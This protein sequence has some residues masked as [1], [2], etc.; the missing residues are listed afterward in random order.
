MVSTAL[1]AF[2]VLAFTGS[3]A[4]KLVT[5]AL[6]FYLREGLRAS[7]L[8]VSTLTAGYMLGRS[9]TAYFSGRVGERWR[10]TPSL[11]LILSGLL[12][13]LYPLARSWYEVSGLSFI[14]GALMGLT[15]PVIQHRVMASA[16]DGR[17]G[18][19]ISSYFFIGSMAGPAGDAIYGV[20]LSGSPLLSV[21]TVSLSLYFISS[22]IAYLGSSRLVIT[23]E[24]G[25]MG[26]NGGVRWL[27][28]LGF[29]IGGMASIVGSSITYVIMREWFLLSRGA[30]ALILSAVGGLSLGSKL[31]S[32]YLLDEL[33]AGPTLKSLVAL[34]VA[35][36]LLMGIKSLPCFLAGLF[37]TFIVVGS[38][39]PV[40]RALAHAAPDPASAVGKLNSFGNVGTV[41]GLLVVGAG[42]DVL[43]PSGVFSPLIVL[44]GPYALLTAISTLKIL[45][46]GS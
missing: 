40:S 31:L 32:G 44:L 30:V 42:I 43:P 7:F 34:L 12:V 14:Q 8:G 25:G 16:G 13:L 46:E 1:I 18:R 45:R 22:L 20:F 3:L 23:R 4:T 21:V 41:T 29:G 35:G 27:L 26:R 17:I 37:L 11:C 15:W 24:G 36:T 10:F 28:V 2:T 5:P 19:A 33:G 9:T 6:S 38:F 39:I